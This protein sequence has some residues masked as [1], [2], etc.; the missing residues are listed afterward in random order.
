[1][2]DKGDKRIQK[3]RTTRLT[4]EKILDRDDLTGLLVQVRDILPVTDSI[5]IVVRLQSGDTEV[6]SNYFD[7]QAIAGL[8]SQGLHLALSEGDKHE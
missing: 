7:I 6:L 8:L 3:R 4:V 5:V 1:M 2:V